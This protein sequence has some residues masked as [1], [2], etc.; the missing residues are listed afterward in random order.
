MAKKKRPILEALE[1]LHYTPLDVRAALYP[2]LA[3]T[4]SAHLED[5]WAD[6]EPGDLGMLGTALSDIG[7]WM[8][9]EAKARAGE[10]IRGGLGDSAKM[11]SG[12]CKFAWKAPTSQTRV[13]SAKLKELFPQ[14]DY[15]DLYTKS[16]V[17]ESISIEVIT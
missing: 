13:D 14:K 15:P 2:A 8:T 12:R 4:V 11:L 7:E 3:R 5:P 10:S 6:M 17:S 16:P 9:D 1:L